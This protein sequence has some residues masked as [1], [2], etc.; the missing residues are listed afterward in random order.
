MDG[1]GGGGRGLNGNEDNFVDNDNILDPEVAPACGIHCLG[2]MQILLA[3]DTRT[4]RVVKSV[5]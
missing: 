1:G 4:G 2:A 5:I 3:A